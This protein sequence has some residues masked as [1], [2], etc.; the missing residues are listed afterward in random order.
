MKTLKSWSDSLR[1]KIHEWL[2]QIGGDLGGMLVYHSL[3]STGVVEQ[4]F[5][6]AVYST[7]ESKTDGQN[8]SLMQRY[9]EDQC[10]HFRK[11]ILKQPNFE[12]WTKRDL[13][14]ANSMGL[15]SCFISVIWKCTPPKGW[16][17]TNM[18]Y[19]LDHVTP[20]HLAEN[21]NLIYVVMYARP[22]WFADYRCIL[23]EIT[24]GND[25][26]YAAFREAYDKGN[27]QEVDPKTL[28]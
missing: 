21:P 19:S 22:H 27:W 11:A 10:R 2:F 16:S 9:I 14:W 18:P 13:V 7:K 8:K 25:S 26:G 28:A 15:K 24:Y 4:T 20:E 23:F 3:S 17:A 5:Y 1:R 12:L 6:K